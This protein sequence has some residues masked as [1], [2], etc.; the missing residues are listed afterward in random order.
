MVKIM[1][2]WARNNLQLDHDPQV[3]EEHHTSYW[4]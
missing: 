4:K 1:T 3:C 2:V